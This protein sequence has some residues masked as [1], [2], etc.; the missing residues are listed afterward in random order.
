MLY[1]LYVVYYSLDTGA[2]VICTVKFPFLIDGLL[3]CTLFWMLSCQT[4]LLQNI[5]FT[6]S[7][8]ELFRERE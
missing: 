7:V 4:K 1:M 6:S 3:R 8:R 2:L 5:Y